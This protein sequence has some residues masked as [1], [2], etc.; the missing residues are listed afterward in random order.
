[1]TSTE[2]HGIFVKKFDE[3]TALVLNFNLKTLKLVK[4]G[5]ILKSWAFDSETKVSKLAEIINQFE[6]F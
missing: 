5:E 1:M 4:N 6:T 2:S 3:F